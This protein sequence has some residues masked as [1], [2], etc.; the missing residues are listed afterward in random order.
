MPE[1]QLVAARALG[2]LGSDEAFKV[3]MDGARSLDVNQRRLA[4]RALGD[5]GRP[6]ARDAL[7]TMLKDTDADVRLAA[8]AAI[9]RLP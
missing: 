3:A 2:M 5:I 7:V 8:A 9:L 1:V 6:E 4:A